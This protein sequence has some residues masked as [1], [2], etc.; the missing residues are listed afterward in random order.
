MKKI[1]IIDDENSVTELF[2]QFLEGQGFSVKGAL[3]GK[4]G[5][6][7][8][9]RECP[10]LVITD[11]M[12]PEMDGLELIRAVRKLHPDLPVVAISGGMK[13]TPMNFLPQAKLFGACRIIEKPIS[14]SELLE[15]VND[16]LGG[17]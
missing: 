12:M 16:L 14:L 17:T 15:V 4:E 5:L 11:I 3:D 10:D 13:A 1:L 9:E 7:S 6:R 8:L 2:T